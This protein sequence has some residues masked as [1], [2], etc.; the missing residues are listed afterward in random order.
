M[1]LLGPAIGPILGG[2]ITQSVGW[3]W[4]FW[5]VSIFDALVIIFGY[6][7]LRE[8]YRPVILSRKATLLRKTS[9]LNYY[10]EV[11]NIRLS[12]KLQAALTRPVRLLC[13][14]PA[15]QLISLFLAYNFGILYITLS[16]YADIFTQ[17]YHQ[18]ASISGLHYIALVIGYTIAA[19]VGARLTDRLW[20]HLSRKAGGATAPEYRVPLMVPGA[21]LIPICLFWYGWAAEARVHWN[22]TDVGAGIYGCGIILGTQAM[23]LYV[24]D[25]YA[26]YTASAAA[27]AQ[28]L[29]SITGFAFPIFAPQMYQTLGYGWGNS[30]LAFLF[31]ALGVPAPLLLWKYGA[32]LRA[33][34]KPQW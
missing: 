30:V 5:T 13:T 7:V 27:A 19:Q 2:V 25:A 6:F 21:V 22:I 11:D 29:R 28:L 33:M 9:S 3:R 26:E 31:L 14:Q 1:P 8:S 12:K 24:L 15:L 20:A 23:H 17:Q 16:T 10:A 18:S 34:G 32:K 4:L